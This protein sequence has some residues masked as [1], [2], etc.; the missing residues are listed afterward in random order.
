VQ[1]AVVVQPLTAAQ[2]D[3]YLAQS[4]EQLTA[5]R[6]L[7][8]DDAALRELADTPLMLSIMVLAYRG[9]AIN[10]LRADRSLDERR[11]HVFDSYIQRMLARRGASAHYTSQQTLAW[12]AWLARSMVQRSQT[13]FFLEGLQPDWLHIA[14]YLRYY[15]IGVGLIVGLA[16]GVA[17]G[18]SLGLAYGVFNPL[19]GYIFGIASGI[20]VALTFG[21]V[22][23]QALWNALKQPTKPWSIG[24]SL[25][26]GTIIGL[27]IGAAEGLLIGLIG[28]FNI[29]LHIGMLSGVAAGI[30]VGLTVGFASGLIIG[31]IGNLEGIAIIEAL[32]WSW[33]TAQ[34]GLVKK[35]IGGLVAG[36]LFGGANVTVGIFNSD[37]KEGMANG[38]AIGLVVGL[39]T[40]IISGLVSGL[41]ADEIQTKTVPNQGIW[42]SAYNALVLGGA[43][44]SIVGLL[45]AL[46]YWLIREPFG[47]QYGIA[48]ELAAG[49]TAGFMTG[50]AV[51]LIYGGLS[52][53]QHLVLRLLLWHSGAMPWNYTRFLDY[54]AE[55]LLL[56]KVG[57]GYMFVHR[58]LLEH[59]AGRANAPSDGANA[60][61]ELMMSTDESSV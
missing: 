28:I 8:Q 5:V 48:F 13:S 34:T 15:T 45:T 61:L 24:K 60:T 27:L 44:A 38:L 40:I 25:G 54:A 7:L 31:L 21:L 19:K 57:G 26:R 2:V 49:M 30:T 4:G 18:L 1:G 3:A 6:T 12:L 10:T 29:D 9:I 41:T 22:I 32:H 23:Q 17:T 43:A 14:H 51:G 46:I 59:F 52:S 56:R 58:L 11:A 42:R 37:A 47:L 36:L 53:I 16:V 35:V 20:C 39:S 50:S 55:R 33:A